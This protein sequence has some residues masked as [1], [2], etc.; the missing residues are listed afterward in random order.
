V[1]RAAEAARESASQC[2]LA[3]AGHVLDER[4]TAGEQRARD[5]FHGPA[6]PVHDLLDVGHDPVGSRR[7]LVTRGQGCLVR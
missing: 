1:E 6:A 3:A 5:Q 4:M 2:R 7:E